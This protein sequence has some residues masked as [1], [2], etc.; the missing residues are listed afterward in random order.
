MPNHARVLQI[1]LRRAVAIA[2]LA[3]GGGAMLL[4]ASIATAYPNYRLNADGGYCVTCHGDFDGPTSP[5]GTFFPSA[6]KHYM[7]RNS[8]YMDTDCLLCHFQ[9]GDNPQTGA[10][11][12]SGSVPGFGC[13]GCHGVD[14]GGAIGVSGVGLRAHHAQAG[15]AVCA[16]CHDNDPAPLPERFEPPYYGTAGT[17]VTEPCNVSASLAENWTF[18]DTL[19][20]DNDGDGLYDGDDPDCSCPADNTADGQVS[21]SDL[22]NQLADWGACPTGC[23]TDIDADRDID[24]SDLL[25]LLADWGPCP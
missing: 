12:G 2:G 19:G 18:G 22:L 1:R 23:I 11:A 4:L 24:V 16:E 25:F 15:V 13:V 14:Y 10:S 7:H 21:V 6:D 20:L 17:R 5:K 9:T 8:S 3:I